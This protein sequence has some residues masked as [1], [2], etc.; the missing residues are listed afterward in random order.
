MALIL[1]NREQA[2]GKEDFIFQV[3]GLAK[4]S[5]WPQR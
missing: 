5:M 1:K 3:P 4:D 2:E